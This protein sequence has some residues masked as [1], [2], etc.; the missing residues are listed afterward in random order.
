MLN[1]NQA[2]LI[3]IPGNVNSMKIF[4][5]EGK[6]PL[7]NVTNVCF[8]SIFYRESCS[9]CVSVRVNMVIAVIFILIIC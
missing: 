6:F 3:N 4:S 8:F 5:W 9:V 1:N 7:F 2:H